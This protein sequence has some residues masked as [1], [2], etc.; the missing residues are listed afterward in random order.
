M[1]RIAF[2][3]LI[4][5]FI[6]IFILLSI[7]TPIDQTPYENLEAYKSTMDRVQ[8]LPISTSDTSKIFFAG[9][10]KQNLLPSFSTPIA[11]DAAR[12]GK[13]FESIRDSIYVRSFVFKLGK[14]KVAYVS[15]DLLIIPPN[16]LEIVDSLLLNKGFSKENIY[17]TATHTH[18][19]IGAWY[20]SIVGEIF[21]GKFDNRIPLHIANTIALSIEKAEASLSPSTIGSMIVPTQE[22]VVNRLVGNIGLV[23]SSMRML[24]VRNDKGD[25]ALLFSFTAHA[26]IFHENTM[27]ISGDW[28][29]ETI[30]KIEKS[31]PSL[32]CVFSAGAVGSHGPFEHSKN[33]QIEIEFISS[34]A[35]KLILQ[36]LDSLELKNV[37]ELAMSFFPIQ[38]REP[39]FRVAKNI[40]IRPMWFEK[41]FGK[42]N[43]HINF[44][45]LGDNFMVGM[46]CDFSGELTY[47]I[48]PKVKA[49]NNH[50]FI[51]SFNGGYTGYITHDKWYDLDEYETRTMAWLGRGNGAYFSEII[52]NGFD[53]IVK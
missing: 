5:F 39:H 13:H 1:K 36:Y 8:N 38:T 31:N 27:Y 16:V 52:R 9:W 40:A 2:Y 35:S 14:T 50:L 17:Y 32:F 47:N 44:L 18:S 24:K 33:Q 43:L 10:S 7:F 29:S 42:Q 53:R 6:I 11:I 4:P 22:L 25:E 26:T 12:D 23:D 28:P 21:A 48:E 15:A 46:P 3:F 30:S 41:I 20:N 37:H 19:S 34:K 45:K 49:K 51:T